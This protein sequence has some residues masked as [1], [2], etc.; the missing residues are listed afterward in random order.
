MISLIICSKYDHLSDSLIKNIDQTIG[1]G[2]EIVHIDNSQHQYS[3]YSAYNEGVK[4]SNGDILCFMHEDLYFHTQDWGK[5]VC[6]YMQDDSIG[7]LGIAG[8][9]IIPSKGDIRMCPTFKGYQ[10]DGITTL[11]TPSRYVVS[12]KRY[13]P[14]RRLEEVAAIDGLWFCIPKSLFSDI[15]FDEY[16]FKGFHLYD[17]DNSMQVI[18]QGRKI[19]ICDDISIE[20]KSLGVFSMVFYDN[21]LK[22]IKKWERKLPVQRGICFNEAELSS[23]SD[24]AE[25]LLRNRIEKDRAVLSVIKKQKTG[26]TNYSSEEKRAIDRTI[27][28]YAKYNYQNTDNIADAFKMLGKLL[29]ERPVSFSLQLDIIGKFLYYGVIHR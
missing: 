5:K 22:F 17:V 23:I 12:K 27:K 1:T 21:L 18:Q 3:I 7:I 10:Y 2:Y 25:R 24:K 15:S 16:T 4:H 19:M 26:N 14:T 20:H 8:T 6:E 29:R 11:E 13:T 9:K 28:K